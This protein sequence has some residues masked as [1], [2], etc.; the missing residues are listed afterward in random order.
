[1]Q[2]ERLLAKAADSWHFD[3][4]ELSTATCG[5]PLSTLAFYLI[6]T[7]TQGLVEQFKIHKGKVCEAPM[8]CQEM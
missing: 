8:P 6:T 1:M 3:A 7:S 5:H 2:V 4:F